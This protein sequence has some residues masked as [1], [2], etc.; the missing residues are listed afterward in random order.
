MKNRFLI[1]VFVLFNSITAYCQQ[2]YFSLSEI[3]FSV[4]ED[5]AR[6]S[7]KAWVEFSFASKNLGA[8]DYLKIEL[9][10]SMDDFSL[11]QL[12]ATIGR[13]DEKIYMT[14]LGQTYEVFK[15]GGSI[16]FE[17]PVE[18]TRKWKFTRISAELLNGD[19]TKYLY[20]RWN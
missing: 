18:V 1:I 7:G 11:Q 9:G 6:Q 12:K 15:T 5:S 3:E 2:G 20:H 17:L 19:H 16:S 14:L 10:A 13:E 8:A 4:S